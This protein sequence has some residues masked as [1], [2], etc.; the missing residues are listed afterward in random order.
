MS[1]S[2]TFNI[3]F[4]HRVFLHLTFCFIMLFFLAIAMLI[5]NFDMKLSSSLLSQ[6]KNEYKTFFLENKISSIN[7]SSSELMEDLFSKQERY[8]LAINRLERLESFVHS[9]ESI[10]M[11]TVTEQLGSYMKET[12]LNEIPNGFPIPDAKI[13]SRYGERVHPV[14]KVKQIHHGIDFPA[15]IGTPIYSPA[16]GVVEAIRVSTQGSGNFMRLQHTYGFSSS[17]SHLH[18][19]SVKEG[20]FVKKGELIA[21]SGN[22]GLSSGPHLHYEIRFLGKSLDP[23]P[24]IKWN[25]DNFSEITNKVPL[26]KWDELLTNIEIRIAMNPNLNAQ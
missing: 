13:S 7:S 26:I 25:Y 5:F 24:F 18:K 23:H 21:Y 22:T 11:V 19:F 10:D 3:K 20:D 16:D 2:K 1:G 8:E 12:V 17:Y 6:I 4:R 9:A 14:T 15:A